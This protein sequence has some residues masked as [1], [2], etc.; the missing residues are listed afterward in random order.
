MGIQGPVA[1]GPVAPGSI[2]QGGAANR[3]PFA[4]AQS[5]DQGYAADQSRSRSLRVYAIVLGLFGTAFVMMVVAVVGV[6]FVPGLL[7]GEGKGDGVAAVE[8]GPVVNN[9][10]KKKGKAEDTAVADVDVPSAPVKVHKNPGGGGGGTPAPP[11]QP[12]S[13]KGPAAVTVKV[14]AGTPSTGVEITCPGGFRNRGTFASDVAVVSNVPQEDCTVFFK[15]GPPA[16]YKPVHGGQT[17][18]CSFQGTTALCK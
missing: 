12:Q 11:K 13:P 10:P 1:S 18:T 9:E 7:K 16:K 4:A 5:V 2:A 15:G 17:L 3:S 6:I 8:P 14:A